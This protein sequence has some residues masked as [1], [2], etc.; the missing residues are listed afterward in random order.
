MY[1]LCTMEKIFQPLTGSGGCCGSFSLENLKDYV[2]SVQN[3]VDLL[4]YLFKKFF[5]AWSKA[6]VDHC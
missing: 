5:A 4:F 1:K 6:K 2:V 3:L